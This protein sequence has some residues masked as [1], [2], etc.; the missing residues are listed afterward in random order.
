MPAAIV[1]PFVMQCPHLALYIARRNSGKSYL[2]RHL[3]HVLAKGKRFK[4]V[5][6]ISP[7]SFKRGVKCH[8]R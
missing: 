8:R 5:I 2:M 1:K 3:L 7:L 6:V 4:W